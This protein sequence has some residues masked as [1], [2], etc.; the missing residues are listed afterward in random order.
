[1]N[2]KMRELQAQI[3]ALTDQAKSYL[4]DGEGKDVAKAEETLNKIDELQKEFDLEERLF[5]AT[6]DAAPAEPQD[7]PKPDSVKEFAAAVR[8]GF[9]SMNEGTGADGGYTVPED[10][11]TQ[12]NHYRDA[13]RSLRDLVQV[14]PV[15]TN[16]GARTF[17]ARAQQTGFALVGEGQPI[18]Q[19]AT[20]QFTRISY[21][22]KKY[23]GIYPATNELL[24]D[25]DANIV[26]EIAIWAGDESRV[27]DNKLILGVINSKNVAVLSGLDDIKHAVNVDLGQA[28]KPTSVV[29]TNDDGMQFLDTLK[30]GIGNYILQRDLADPRRLHL[31]A[32]ATALPLE[33]LPNADLPGEEVYN[34]TTD[35][36]IVAG[37]DYYTRS[38][39]GTAESPYV[40]TKVDNPSAASLGSYYNKFNGIPLIVGDL[41][42]G[43]ILWDRQ[44]LTLKQSDVAV[45]GSGDTYVNAFEDDMMLIR[46]IQR[47]DVTVRDSAAFVRGQ[48]QVLV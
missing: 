1:M 20:P 9:K 23:A 48:I 47:E 13:R 45:V 40:Y 17:K 46:A 36:E 21:N 4:A 25:S 27:T 24:A 28:F 5:K 38:G 19:K 39:S 31:S 3:L 10:I 43:I 33:V 14:I 41:K 42:E 16:S 30:D 44:H 7:Q 37:R 6:K 8:R 34:L 26:R 11:R 32:G 18:G 15:T 12:I 2:K 22:I 29:V 35:T